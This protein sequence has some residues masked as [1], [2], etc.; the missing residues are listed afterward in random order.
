MATPQFHPPIQPDDPTDPL[1]DLV[2]K[3]T[4]GMNKQ[5]AGDLKLKGIQAISNVKRGVNKSERI[6]NK[7]IN[8][9]IKRREQEIEFLKYFNQPLPEKQ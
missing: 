9:A 7:L 3:Y 2:R 4:K 1:Y 5:I 8:V 6:W